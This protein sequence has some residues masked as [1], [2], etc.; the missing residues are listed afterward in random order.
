MTPLTVG[1]TD[2]SQIHILVARRSLMHGPEID[3]CTAYM[4]A[5]SSIFRAHILEDGSFGR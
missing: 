5:S 4:M 3:G 2:K 1:N